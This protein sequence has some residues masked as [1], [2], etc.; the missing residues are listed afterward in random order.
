MHSTHQNI[1][2]SGSTQF[3]SAYMC[4]CAL[5][6]QNQHFCPQNDFSSKMTNKLHILKCYF[7]KNARSFYLFFNARVTESK[8][9]WICIFF[10]GKKLL[11]FEYALRFPNIATTLLVFGML[12]SFFAWTFGIRVVWNICKLMTSCCTLITGTIP[13]ASLME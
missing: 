5:L 12:K 1:Y 3:K 8:L 9:F 10:G 6:Q 4:F 2:Q 11:H 7:G 13:S